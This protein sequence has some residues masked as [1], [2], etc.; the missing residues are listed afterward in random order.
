MDNVQVQLWWQY[1]DDVTKCNVNDIELGVNKEINQMIKKAS[2]T[3]VD[4][5]MLSQ[6][7]LRKVVGIRWVITDR[8]RSNGGIDR[9]KCSFCGFSQ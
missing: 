4:A 7:Q 8:S 9:I 2:F 3:E 1:E 5:S 6:E